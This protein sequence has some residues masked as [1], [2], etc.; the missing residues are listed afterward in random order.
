MKYQEAYVELQ[1]ML[2][3]ITFRMHHAML[4]ELKDLDEDQL[5]RMAELFE[6]V[7]ERSSDNTITQFVFDYPEQLEVLID[8]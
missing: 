5:V 7:Q 3:P 6:I 4:A 8:E 2:E 1:E